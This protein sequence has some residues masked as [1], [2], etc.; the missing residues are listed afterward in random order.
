[1]P[2]RLPRWLIL[3]VIVVAL[4]LGGLSSLGVA[5]VRRPFPQV[6]GE[7]ALP[8]L[9]RPVEVLR[10]ANGVPHLYADDPQDLFAAQGFVHAQDRFFEMDLRRHITAGRLSELFGPSQVTTDAFIR[11]MGWRRVA[12][13]EVELLSASARRYLDAYAS[14]VNAYLRGRSTSDISLEYTL[15]GIQG[16]RYEP[17][18]WT[19]V[20]SLAWL[21]AMAWDLSAN[22]SQEIDQAADRR[23]GRQGTGHRA[24]ARL[25]DA[26][27][28]TRSSPPARSRTAPSTRRPVRP[29]SPPP[30]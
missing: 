21:K 20:D 18:K 30:R 11:T 6:E 4:A 17:E 25:S 15:L 2:G 3:T 14:G 1:M 8:G 28:S 9:S 5:T 13:Q 19:A 27:T 10:D 12:E 24:L 29:R 16:L 7:I 26:P 23:R 22:R